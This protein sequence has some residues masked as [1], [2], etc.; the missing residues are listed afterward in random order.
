M[1]NTITLRS[2]AGKM[3]EYHFM[4]CKQANGTNF[5]FVKPTRVMPDG[6]TEMILSEA[7]RNN[8]DSQYFIRD[9]E[10]I[11]VKDGTV[12]NL[13]N[14]LERNKW[15]A[16]KDSDLIV[17]SRD[18]KDTN[19]NNAIDG[20]KTRYGIAE[21]WVEVPGYESE[22]V[23]TKKKLITQAWTYIEKD[24][25]DGR[26]T[27]CKI[28]GKNLRN[29][30]TPDVEAYLYEIAEKNPKQIID[31]YTNGD[32]ALRLL[33]I[34]SVDK[35]VIIK[36]SG[37]YFY[38]DT[39]LGGSEDAV[40]YFF[41]LPTNKAILDLIKNQTYPEFIPRALQNKL[42]DEVVNP[43][44]PETP[45]EEPVSEEPVSEEAKKSPKKK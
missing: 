14:P 37:L 12:F 30:P 39:I 43:S 38:G 1:N 17:P 32:T 45:V 34:D 4:P 21:L 3:K 16:I 19:G 9:D 31:L 5:P 11:V 10:D 41:K 22:K 27:K 13:D 24:S 7:E 35:H 18:T 8:P 33:F 26:L 15:L 29:A 28:L 2:W 25:V 20:D 42:L 44:V 40:I 23:V 6:S 36:K